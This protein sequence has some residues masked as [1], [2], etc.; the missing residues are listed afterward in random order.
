MHYDPMRLSRI[1][2]NEIRTTG[3]KLTLSGYMG[4]LY[5]P[6]WITVPT[7]STKR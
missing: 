2:E 5:G 7:S 6:I 4:E 1:Q 3:E